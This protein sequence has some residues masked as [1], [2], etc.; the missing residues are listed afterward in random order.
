M[1][2]HRVCRCRSLSSQ[3][4]NRICLACAGVLR[5][6][7]VTHGAA[8]QRA[9]LD[10]NGDIAAWAPPPVYRTALT[11]VLHAG[12]KRQAAVIV[13]PKPLGP[14]GHPCLAPWKDHAADH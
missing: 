3:R 14:T 4:H 1:F 9:V 8:R 6:A 2:V 5:V 7:R 13:T 10:H 12:K 11:R